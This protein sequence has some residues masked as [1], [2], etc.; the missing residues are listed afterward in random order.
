MTFRSMT[1]LAFAGLAASATPI[2][3]APAPSDY[4]VR[5]LNVIADNLRAQ[6]RI[7]Y[8]GA[9]H[10]S[11]DGQDWV[12][13]FN[14]AASN[15]TVDAANC[16]VDF[17]WTTGVD[18]KPAQDFDTGFVFSSLRGVALTSM[19]Q[20]VNHLSESGGHPSW[21]GR[22]TPSVWVVTATSASGKNYVAD[23]RDYGV[24]ERVV[25]A[26]RHAIALCG[27]K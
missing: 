22:V 8:A 11:A 4:L 19:E 2:M 24:A 20:D 10:D 26:M 6:G 16:S 21:T 12:N 13:Q 14:V 27:T 7:D 18:G 5:T 3:A 1:T 25:A 15:V 17:H 23:F 9:M